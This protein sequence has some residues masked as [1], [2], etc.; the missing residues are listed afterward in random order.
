MPRVFAI[1]WDKSAVIDRAYSGKWAAQLPVVQSHR[2]GG[3]DIKKM[4]RSLREERTG[5]WIHYKRNSLLELEP[6]PVC[7]LFGGFA[8]FS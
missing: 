2:R 6:P 7:A 8:I 3:R 1:E 5:W 4:P